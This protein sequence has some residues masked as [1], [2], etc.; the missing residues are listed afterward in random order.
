MKDQKG[1]KRS[2]IIK[3]TI[4][5][6]ITMLIVTISSWLQATTAP[7][8]ED[9][10]REMDLWSDFIA[11]I[12]AGHQAS[13][14]AFLHN[15]FWP[16]IWPDDCLNV[17]PLQALKL[18]F[19]PQTIG[20]PFSAGLSGRL[21]TS[22]NLVIRD[23]FYPSLQFFIDGLPTRTM[24]LYCYAFENYD[25]IDYLT[26]RL[27]HTLQSINDRILLPQPPSPVLWLHQ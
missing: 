9:C 2:A 24:R 15:Q 4:L 22:S 3:S 10:L 26:D 5:Y 13:G 23:Y 21:P 8:K 17:E 7:T 18:Y 1:Q 12:V 6:A 16:A 19:R 14:T 20:D 25:R 11:L 27:E